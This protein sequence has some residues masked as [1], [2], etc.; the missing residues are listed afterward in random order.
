MR[1]GLQPATCS[2]CRG[3]CT[4]YSCRLTCHSTSGLSGRAAPAA[5]KHR[6][7]PLAPGREM[8]RL[9]LHGAGCSASR[10]G[11]QGPS[12][13]S[14]GAATPKSCG[15]LAAAARAW[16]RTR[17]CCRRTAASAPPSTGRTLRMWPRGCPGGG[18]CRPRAR[19]RTCARRP[20]RRWRAAACT[21]LRSRPCGRRP[22][23]PRMSWRGWR[24]RCRARPYPTA[25]SPR[26]RTTS[27]WTAT[28]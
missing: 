9:I 6:H 11:W 19:R 1:G 2:S 28:G 27:T 18:A 8:R 7:G 16:A 25:T 22:T 24:P 5:S 10:P 17:W 13:R 21:P 15:A 14:C 20:R 4:E 23:Y 3:V 12:R 26:A